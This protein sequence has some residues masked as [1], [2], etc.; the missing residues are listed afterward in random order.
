MAIISSQLTEHQEQIVLELLETRK[1]KRRSDVVRS[2]IEEAERPKL[3]LYARIEEAQAELAQQAAAL[4]ETHRIL[5]EQQAALQQ[6][7]LSALSESFSFRVSKLQD[8]YEGSFEQYLREVEWGDTTLSAKTLLQK[9]GI[10]AAENIHGEFCFGSNMQ[11]AFRSFYE[12]RR[13]VNHDD[14][15]AAAALS[16]QLATPSTC[17]IGNLIVCVPG[18]KSKQPVSSLAEVDELQAA[19]I[20]LEVDLVY[21]EALLQT[22]LGGDKSLATEVAYYGDSKLEHKYLRQIVTVADMQKLHDYKETLRKAEEDRL[23]RKQLLSAKTE[24]CQ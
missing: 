19:L 11:Q 17:D 1:L 21:N 14:R 16:M 22:L 3:S 15:I 5:R 9:F 13:F 20:A 6:A 18:N 8:A 24:N 10:I 7:E 4:T 2:L 23:L 12:S